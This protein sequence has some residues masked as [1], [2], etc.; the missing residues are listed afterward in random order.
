MAFDHCGSGADQAALS[1]S[2]SGPMNRPAI[3]LYLGAVHLHAYS[4]GV[5]LGASPHCLLD[6]AFNLRRSNFWLNLYFVEDPGHSSE[7]FHRGLSQ[8]FLV[9]PVNG[10]FQSHPAILDNHFDFVAG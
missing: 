3:K 4:A 8:R 6:F 5:K 7:L 9:L 2:S 10:T 1:A